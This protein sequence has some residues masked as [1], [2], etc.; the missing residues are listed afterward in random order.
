[1]PSRDTAAASFGRGGRPPFVAP[2]GHTRRVPDGEGAG[3]PHIDS[4]H[5]REGRRWPRQ[6]QQA[7]GPVGMVQTSTANEP[8]SAAA[9]RTSRRIT[10]P[11]AH[12]G[13]PRGDIARSR[14]S[15]EVRAFARPLRSGAPI[16]IFT[17]PLFVGEAEMSLPGRNDPCWCGSGKKYKKCHLD[18]DARGE[19]TPTTAA[20]R[21]APAKGTVRPGFVGAGRPVPVEIWRPPY[22]E[23]GDPGPRTKRSCVKTPDEIE[24][25]RAANKLARVVLDHVVRHVRPGITTDE[26]DAIAHA[27]T[28]ELG[29]YPSPLNYHGFPKSICTSVNEVICHGI[30]DSRALNDGEIVNCDITVYYQG[31]HGDCSETVFV[32]RIDPEARRLVECAYEC[33]MLGIK[34]ALPGR[35]INEIGRAIEAHAKK[36]GYSVV[37]EFSGHGIGADF[38]MEPHVLHYFDRAARTRIDPGMTFTVEPMI[39]QGT[40]RSEIWEDGW[41]AVTLD[42]KLSAQFEHTLLITPQGPELLTAGDGPPW[43]RRQIAAAEG[44]AVEAA[45]A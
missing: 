10:S 32:G 13:S 39:N 1:M 12:S 33:M 24:A 17:R 4:R 8:R 14:I 25:M 36:A 18:T 31:M 23:T 11:P 9:R 20:P 40:W 41:T 35:P 2:R 7:V 37:R 43:F 45:G 42:R 34:A 5:E 22:A 16:A 29:A 30:P 27:K 38:H 15:S 44:A 19:S 6:R 3:A 26:L 21:A 28:I